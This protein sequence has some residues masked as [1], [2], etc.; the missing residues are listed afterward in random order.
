MQDVALNSFTADLGFRR[1]ADPD[2]E[3]V[4]FSPQP[5]PGEDVYARNENFFLHARI[6][7]LK[8]SVFV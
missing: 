5:F 2:P 6:I 8:R 7:E 3:T 1:M 4:F